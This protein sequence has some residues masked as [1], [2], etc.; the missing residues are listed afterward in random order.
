MDLSSA[1][2]ALV[3]TFVC[4]PF[5]DVFF[6]RDPTIVLACRFIVVFIVLDLDLRSMERFIEREERADGGL[7]IIYF[8]EKDWVNMFR[9]WAITG[10]IFK[11]VVPRV[12]PFLELVCYLSIPVVFMASL[13]DCLSIRGCAF[14]TRCCEL[15][16]LLPRL[17]PRLPSFSFLLIILL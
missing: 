5:F 15:L 13:C 9:S 17:G 4:C 10:R 6:L 12:R 16:L 1:V 3:V 11:G 2:D 7:L 8:F 14:L